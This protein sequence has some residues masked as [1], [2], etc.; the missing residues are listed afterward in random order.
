MSTVDRWGQTEMEYSWS[1][2]ACMSSN[3]LEK[4]ADLFGSGSKFALCVLADIHAAHT[5]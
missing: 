5:C 4:A 2:S 1:G 3:L